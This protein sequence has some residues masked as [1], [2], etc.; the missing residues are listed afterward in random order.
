MAESDLTRP[1]SQLIW[2]S[3]AFFGAALALLAASCSNADEALDWQEECRD[4][5]G[6][7]CLLGAMSVKKGTY[8]GEYPPTEPS[9]TAKAE[10]A[11]W[12]STEHAALAVAACRR[13]LDHADEEVRTGALMGL[14]LATL[15]SRSWFDADVE[16]TVAEIVREDPFPEARATAA[17]LLA[18]ASR[19]W[20]DIEERALS[21]LRATV[22]ISRRGF[23]GSVVRLGHSPRINPALDAIGDRVVERTDHEYRNYGRILDYLARRGDPHGPGVVRSIARRAKNGAVRLDCTAVLAAAGKLETEALWSALLTDAHHDM[24]ASLWAIR[25]IRVE[26][27]SEVTAHLV[28]IV[29]ALPGDHG[30]ARRGS[31]SSIAMYLSD[32]ADRTHV[33]REVANALSTTEK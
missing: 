10:A 1:P 21:E 26:P 15:K 9:S 5:Y 24:V 18:N 17:L 28:E 7:W 14:V 8:S 20:P 30:V 33:E 23:V 27:P 29:K 31:R 12:G 22:T 4:I 32:R 19:H 6:K 13:L 25:A 2:L 11:L 3:T 16:R